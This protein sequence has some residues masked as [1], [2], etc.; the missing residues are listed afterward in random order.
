[1]END[2]NLLQERFACFKLHCIVNGMLLI[3]REN[4]PGIHPL[5]GIGAGNR[6]GYL[7]AGCVRLLSTSG[8]TIT[9]IQEKHK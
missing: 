3:L 8:V 1:M 9:Q 4:Q 5:E 7:K 2:P 6:D